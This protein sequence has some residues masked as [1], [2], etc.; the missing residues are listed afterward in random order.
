MFSGSNLTK[1]ITGYEEREIEEMESG[2]RAKLGE[3]MFQEVIFLFCHPIFHGS[4]EFYY[5]VQLLRDV[6]L[7]NKFGFR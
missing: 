3:K 7:A 1:K 5:F 6:Y 4:R 2:T